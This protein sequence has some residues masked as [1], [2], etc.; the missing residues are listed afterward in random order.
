MR[1]IVL[2]AVL[3]GVLAGSALTPSSQAA[4]PDPAAAPGAI[5]TPRSAF[6]EAL[7]QATGAPA[8]AGLGDQATV[9][10]SDDLLLVP[11]EPAARVLN[12][13]N[14]PVPK[15]FVALLIGSDGMDA[16]G[17][18]T[19][20]P[21]GFVDSDAVAAW[22][23]NDILYSLEN[24]VE[25]Q[26]PARIQQ[27]LQPLEA[28]RWVLAPTYNPAKHQLSWAALIIPQSA[29]RESGGEVTF[30]A[31]GFGREG[32]IHLSVVTSE[33]GAS[34]VQRMTAAFLDGLNFGPGKAYSDVKSEDR[35]SPNGLEGAM[36]IISLAKARSS[37]SFWSSDRAIPVVGGAVA[38]IGALA[39]VLN[40]YRQMRINSRR[41]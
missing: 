29:P 38:A 37:D 28:R 20:V 36:G 1:R 7:R 21:S 8:R 31:I 33:Q 4:S 25:Q 3:A 17:M 39:L 16:P 10:L 18:V 26:N 19:F 35:R 24:T 2:A 13:S 14:L 6:A 23:A 40:L 32:Y 12:V 15:D 11:K 41:M 30:H 34:S 5:E 27:G 22:T 9:R